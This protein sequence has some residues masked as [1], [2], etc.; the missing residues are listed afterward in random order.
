VRP[1]RRQRAPPGQPR[2]RRLDARRRDVS[3]P[4]G[5]TWRVA[6]S[7]LWSEIDDDQRSDVQCFIADFRRIADWTTWRNNAKHAEAVRFLAAESARAAADGVPLVVVTHHAPLTR[8]TCRPEH[9][10]SPLSSA[11]QTDLAHLMGA[12]V[13][14]WAYGHTH[15]GCAEQVVAGTRVVTNQRGYPDERVPHGLD[16]FDPLRVWTVLVPSRES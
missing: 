14:A 15:R 6:G 3:T 4:D 2:G 9:S 13:A 10:G 5:G 12:P 1:R 8:G 11:Y 7:T 16:R